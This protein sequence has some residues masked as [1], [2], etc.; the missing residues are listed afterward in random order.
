MQCWVLLSLD[1]LST[2]ICFQKLLSILLP[3]LFS[4]NLANTRFLVYL[5]ILRKSKY[6]IFF[7]FNKH[8][9][10]PKKKT[11]EPEA[12]QILIIPLHCVHVTRLL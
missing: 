9:R 5:Y 2:S 3:P 6:S 12:T 1:S 4:E 7:F 11:T 10:P 8:P